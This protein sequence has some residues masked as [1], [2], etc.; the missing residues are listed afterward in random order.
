M[1]LPIK[2]NEELGKGKNDGKTDGNRIKKDIIKKV[3]TMDEKVKKEIL[4]EVNDNIKEE[5]VKYIYVHRLRSKVRSFKK[6]KKY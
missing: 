5:V 6:I 1:E 4:M 2:Y 3:S